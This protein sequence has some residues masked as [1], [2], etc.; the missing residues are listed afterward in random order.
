MAW[1]PVIAVGQWFA[2]NCLPGIEVVAAAGENAAH[3]CPVS[4]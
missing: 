1:W 2:E 4:G 3:A